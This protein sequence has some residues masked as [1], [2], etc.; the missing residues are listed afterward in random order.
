MPDAIPPKSRPGRRRKAP[1]E[2]MSEVI[3]VRVT[4]G[5]LAEIEAKAFAS[6]YANVTEFARDAIRR[7]PAPAHTRGLIP[8]ALLHELSRIGNNVN[9]I[10]RAANAGRDLPAMAAQTLADLRAL[11]DRITARLSGGD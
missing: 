9:Q 8:P 6:G 1:G 10:A 11:I 2:A 3:R 5:E 7:R 4:P